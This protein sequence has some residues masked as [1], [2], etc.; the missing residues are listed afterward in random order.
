MKT[1]ANAKINK[2]AYGVKVTFAGKAKATDTGITVQ[3]NIKNENGPVI[4]IKD[5]AEIVRD[6]IGLYSAGN[7]TWTIG[8]AKVK[9]ENQ[10]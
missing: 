9:A 1:K 5:G 2:D 6:E 10:H 4:A 3:G 8:N 7:S